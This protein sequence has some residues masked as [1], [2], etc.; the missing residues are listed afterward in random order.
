MLLLMLL[1]YRQNQSVVCEKMVPTSRS[2]GG[3]GDGR[4]APPRGGGEEETY[5]FSSLC[6]Y[7]SHFSASLI[8]F[9][10]SQHAVGAATK[11]AI[12]PAKKVE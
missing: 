9:K 5:A 7:I 4:R 3:E 12:S 11:K 1:D 10:T 6:V 8:A 2:T